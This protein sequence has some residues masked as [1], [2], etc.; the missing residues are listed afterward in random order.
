[1]QLWRLTY[2]LVGM[3]HVTLDFFH[4]IWLSVTCQ[5]IVWELS[6][7]KLLS[8]DQPQICFKSGSFRR[9]EF[10]VKF[11]ESLELWLKKTSGTALRECLNEKIWVRN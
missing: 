2:A 8:N 9:H 7:L 3:D 4:E 11:E 5:D 10:K 6:K 1:M